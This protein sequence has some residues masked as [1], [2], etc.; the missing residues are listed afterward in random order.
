MKWILSVLMLLVLS[1]SSQRM[2]ETNLYFGL[3]KPG[4]GMVTETEW[5]QF[6]ENYISKTFKEGCSILKTTGQWFDPDR[7][8]Q[9]TEPGYKVIYY[10]QKSRTISK[11]VDSLRYWYKTLFQ[12]QSVLRVDRKVN[13]S[14]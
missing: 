7:Q 14:F 3:S 13:A 2:T 4:G 9:I 1:C 6:K 5:N 10:H 8:I 11:Q 12:Q